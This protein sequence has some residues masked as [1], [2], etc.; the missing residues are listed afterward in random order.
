M[1]FEIPDDADD[2]DELCMEL[3]DIASATEFK[4]AALV[5]ARVRVSSHG[6]DRSKSKSGLAPDDGKVTTSVYAR[7]GI[8]GLRSKTTIIRYWNVWEKLVSEGMVEPVSLGDEV[9]IPEDVEWNSYYL[10]AADADEP[11]V[12]EP[13]PQEKERKP[14]QPKPNAPSNA[15]REMGEGDCPPK[16]QPFEDESETEDTPE[17]T[18]V[19]LPEEEDEEEFSERRFNRTLFNFHLGSAQREMNG[20][21]ECLSDM[22]EGDKLPEGS[23]AKIADIIE[24]W[25]DIQNAVEKKEEE[26]NE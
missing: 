17:F 12:D 19:N 11:V 8:H 15:A 26:S 7:K 21:N 1:K 22:E 18:D 4:R 24:A 5:Y 14:R 20:V 2:A 13:E 10:P 23:K 9:D 25:T 6:G 16:A 3:G